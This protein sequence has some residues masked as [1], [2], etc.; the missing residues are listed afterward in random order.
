MT[1]PFSVFKPQKYAIH[2]WITFSFVDAL[3]LWKDRSGWRLIPIPTDP[4]PILEPEIPE[5]DKLY[6][7]WKRRTTD[8]EGL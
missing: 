8:F 1:D 6:E 3:K 2:F 5:I 4:F 7:V